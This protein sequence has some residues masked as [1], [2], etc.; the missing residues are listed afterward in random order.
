MRMSAHPNGTHA[1]RQFTVKVE[2]DHEAECWYVSDTDVPGLATGADTLDELFQ[3]LAVM[4]P[5][6]LEAN[7]L[8]RQSHEDVPFELIA[9]SA[10]IGRS[11][12]NG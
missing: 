9:H 11:R 2:W 3:K 8:I 6:M 7:G 12:L 10:T 4:V 1:M 5:E